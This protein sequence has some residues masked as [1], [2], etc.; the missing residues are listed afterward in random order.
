MNDRCWR[1]NGSRTVARAAAGRPLALH[2]S[3]GDSG[4]NDH[5]SLQSP[6]KTPADDSASSAI[7]EPRP[8]SITTTPKAMLSAA[9]SVRG[10]ESSSGGVSTS[11][12]AYGKK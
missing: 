4:A 2:G 12:N 8:E 6:A 7:D 5:C 3:S 11:M 1:Y 10:V 9:Q